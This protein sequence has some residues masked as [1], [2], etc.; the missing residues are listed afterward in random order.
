MTAYT[1]IYN[2]PP[3][4]SNYLIGD[5][6][7]LTGGDV[8]KYAGNGQWAADAIGLTQAGK[9]FGPYGIRLDAGLSITLAGADT[10]TVVWAP[11]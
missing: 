9:Q 1:S 4:G 7:T 10:V 8:W 5:T 6:V 11:L 2:T 3:S